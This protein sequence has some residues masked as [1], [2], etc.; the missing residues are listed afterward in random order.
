MPSTYHC[1]WLKLRVSKEPLGGR[2]GR[3]RRGQVLRHDDLPG[4]RVKLDLDLDLDLVAGLSDGV[5]RPAG[6]ADREPPGEWAAGGWSASDA[7]RL[8]TSRR[9]RD[10]LGL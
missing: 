8:D 2:R 1:F 3:E 6:D 9:Q 4:C 5:Q 7:H 10:E